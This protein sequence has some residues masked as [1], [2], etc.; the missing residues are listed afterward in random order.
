MAE[1]VM[2][3]DTEETMVIFSVHLEE[4]FDRRLRIRRRAGKIEYTVGDGRR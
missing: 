1:V 4:T 2:Q 3:P